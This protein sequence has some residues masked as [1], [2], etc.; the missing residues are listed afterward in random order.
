MGKRLFWDN[1][2]HVSE[3][4]VSTEDPNRADPGSERI[5]LQVDQPQLEHN[6]GALA[7]GTDGYLYVALGDGG[8]SSDNHPG[9]A[10]EGNGQATATLLGKILRIDVDGD[11]YAIPPDNPFVDRPGYRPEIFALGMRNP[12]RCTFDAGGERELF[13]GDV[14][15]GGFEEVD[16]VRRGGNYGW[17][18]KEGRHCFDPDNPYEHPKGCADDGLIDPIIEYVNCK[19][20]DAC[21]GRSIIGGYVY[22]GEAIPELYGKYL[23]GDWS[24]M[25]DD[26]GPSIFVGSPPADGGDGPWT[27]APLEIA[28]VEFEHWLLAF[29]Q[30][31]DNELYVLATDAVGP[32]PE[33]AEGKIYKIVPAR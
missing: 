30:D 31:A 10:P 14:G 19:T 33:R 17:R 20:T 15:Q 24:A 16:I 6:A 21:T 3:F 12:Y 9:H 4:R 7:F 8:G 28:N 1:T 23:F 32:D 22:R 26:I 18:L 2:S 5:L 27:F 13:C 25:P 11:P 29:G